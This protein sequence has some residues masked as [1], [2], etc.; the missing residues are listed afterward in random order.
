M[1]DSYIELK[2]QDVIRFEHTPASGRV[3][4]YYSY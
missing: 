1:I 3:L 2:M 4:M